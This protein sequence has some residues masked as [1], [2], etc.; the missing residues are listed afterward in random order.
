[1]PSDLRTEIKQTRP[2]SNIH[3]EA[4]LNIART[5]AVLGHEFAEALK[6]YG[7]TWTQYNVLRILRGAGQEGL[8]RQEVRERL[9][10]QVPDVTR[11]LDRM[12][13]ADLIT[14]SRG[15]EDRRFVTTRISP[16]GLRL[17]AQLEEPVRL[18][19][20]RQ[21]GH[22]SRAQLKEMIS[23]LSVARSRS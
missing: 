9:V 18:A 5:W 14:R 13:E 6:P 8:C 3:E 12:E 20:E 19:L 17:L 16:A 1:M 23:L 10:A 2:W 7:V 4:H 15:D 22:M 11:L 21:L